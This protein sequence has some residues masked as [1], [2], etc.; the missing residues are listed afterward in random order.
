MGSGKLEDI[1]SL[2]ITNI[3]HFH[4]IVPGDVI[5]DH[6]STNEVDDTDSLKRKVGN[7]HY[8]IFCLK[9]KYHVMKIL[10][11]YSILTDYQ[12]RM[13]LRSQQLRL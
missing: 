6:F 3:W 8:E 12:D 2:F 10:S 5:Y 4:I 9:D 13:C 1:E 7:H 11:N